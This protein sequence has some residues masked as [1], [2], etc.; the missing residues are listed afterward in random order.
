M[1]HLVHLL[2]VILLVVV[3]WKVAASPGRANPQAIQ[4]GL[5][6]VQIVLAVLGGL[7]GG[8]I[9]YAATQSGGA[10]NP[11]AIVLGAGIGFALIWG[12]M[13]VVIWI[14]NG[15]LTR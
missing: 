7:L 6:R 2:L 12:A 5:Y 13:T 15:F 11:G 8:V 1:V 10:E 4:T 9:G 3:I 14:I